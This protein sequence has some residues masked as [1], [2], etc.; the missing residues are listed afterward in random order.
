MR[1]IDPNTLSNLEERV[2]RINRVAKTYK[3]GRTP[4]FNVLVVV[5]DGNGHVGAGI[6]KAREVPEAIRKGVE[7]AKKNIIAIPRVA[8][9]IPHMVIGRAGASEVLLKP[10]S[11][12]TGV[13]A[14]G[15]VRAVLEAAGVS[16]VLSKSLGSSN[17]INTVWAAMDGL[18]RLKR[19]E[20]VARMR[21]KT[22]E[23]LVPWLRESR[24]VLAAEEEG[25][26][27]EAVEEEAVAAETPEAQAETAEAAQV[28]AEEVA[29]AQTSEPTAEAAET[30]ATG[31]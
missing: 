2:V 13:I 17:A 25:A 22:A 24:S 23:E 12:G 10:A 20:E 11:P 8:T 7:D 9:T 26:E 19:A 3:G 21:G 6:G 28:P 14:G 1:R 29:E 4:S 30:Q 18:R 5:G 15:A 27:A 31:E 16:D